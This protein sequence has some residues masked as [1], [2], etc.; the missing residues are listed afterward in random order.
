MEA[1]EK[2]LDSKRFFFPLYI[3]NLNL[4]ERLWEFVKKECLSLRYYVCVT[5]FKEAILSYCKNNFTKYKKERLLLLNLG[6]QTFEKSQTVGIRTI[7][8]RKEVSM[9]YYNMYY[10]KHL[11]AP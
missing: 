9:Y 11:F 10:Y 6:N 1:K 3:P 2:K 7:L 8:S 4:I 5:I